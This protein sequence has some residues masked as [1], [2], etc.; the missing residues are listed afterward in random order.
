LCNM[1]T[2]FAAMTGMIAPDEKTFAWLD[3][4]RYAPRGSQLSRALAEWRELRS[5]DGASFDTEIEIDASTLVPM[6]SWGTSPE[7]SAAIDDVVPA[8]APERPLS[9]MGLSA[10][11]RLAGTKID[12]A[13][14]GSCTNSRLSDL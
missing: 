13:F 6:V 5:D 7:H 8:D 12:A 11:Q 10:N 2:E 1:A 14:I 3:G 4:R 9:Y